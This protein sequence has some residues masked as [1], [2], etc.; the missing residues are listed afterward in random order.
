MIIKASTTNLSKGTVSM[1]NKDSVVFAISKS[2][3]IYF[4]YR[5]ERKLIFK[6]IT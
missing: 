3:Q 2:K 5:T 1:H 6:W 4:S